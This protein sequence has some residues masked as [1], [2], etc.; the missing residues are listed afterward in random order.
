MMRMVRL[1][2]KVRKVRLAWKVG[3]GHKEP[4]PTV[5]ALAVLTLN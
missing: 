3:F 2:A 5:A 4:L 1:W